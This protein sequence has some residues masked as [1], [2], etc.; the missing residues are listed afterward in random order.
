MSANATD[1]NVIAGEPE[2]LKWLDVF[3]PVSSIDKN[4]R[5]QEKKEI[6]QNETLQQAKDAFEQ[7]LRKVLG[8][9][10]EAE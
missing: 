4:K 5:E 6:A 9:V 3:E 7:K 2:S 10:P 8:D 1:Q